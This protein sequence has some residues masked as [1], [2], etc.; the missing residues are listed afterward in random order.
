MVGISLDL[1][2]TALKRFCKHPGRDTTK[3][4]CSCKEI[5]LARQHAFLWANVRHDLLRRLN[6][7]AA[8]ARESERCAHYFYKIAAAEAVVPLL[9]LVRI[10]FGDEIP[11]F[12]RVGMLLDAAPILLPVLRQYLVTQRCKFCFVFQAGHFHYSF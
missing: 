12:R 8:E 6:N 7:A 3:R 1:D 9:D 4:H 5:G 2:G 11:E 10:L